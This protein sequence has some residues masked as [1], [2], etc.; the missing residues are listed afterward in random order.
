MIRSAGGHSKWVIVRRKASEGE[1][2]SE[3]VEDRLFSEQGGTEGGIRRD[4]EVLVLAS[5]RSF[6]FVPLSSLC[7]RFPLDLGQ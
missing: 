7:I 4:S 6:A 1:A 3:C 5:A 2:E